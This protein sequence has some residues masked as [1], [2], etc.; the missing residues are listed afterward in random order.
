MNRKEYDHVVV[1]SGA[2]GATIAL[3]LAKK[4]KRILV[5]EQGKPEASIGTFN[6]CL[7]YF[8]L[9]K[10][11]RM[12]HYSEDGI[13][14]W[15]TLMAG[16]STIVSAA[17]GTPCLQ[18]ELSALGIDISKE[19]S[20]I[21]NELPITPYHL[22]RI[23]PGTRRIKESADALGYPMEQMPKFIDPRK[24]RRCGECTLGCKYNAKWTA[25][26][27]LEKSKDYSVEVRYGIKVIR[28][29]EKNGKAEALEILNGRGREKIAA[30]SVILAAGGI[31][32]PVILQNS[33][34]TGAG[35]NLF[36]DIFVN[37]YGTH[38]ELSQAREPQMT[39]VHHGS[40][41]EKGFILSPYI[42]H[43]LQLR[44]IELGL[45]GIKY[46]TN[47]LLGVMVKIRDDN[48]GKVSPSGKYSKQAT[49]ND[50]SKLKEGTDAASEILREAG[51]RRN[52]IMISK[53][54]GA[55]PGGT[56]A[57]GEVVNENLQTDIENFYV[58]DASVLPSAPGLPPIM[59]ILAL[60]K[61][62]AF[63]LN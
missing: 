39:L 36:L 37:V 44:V 24:C 6:N 34:I 7:R 46:N 52:S 62:L 54:Q 49:I 60:A 40:H 43:P 61:R 15:R 47:R 20:E 35:Q 13:I 58:C 25:L 14:L 51:V 48:S 30:N 9:K 63:S 42:N 1:G 18:E 50:R 55:H 8:D 4:G 10:Y 56:A 2:G 16:G 12:P 3:E 21:R 38:P 22:K 31:G 27:F 57:I 17:N 33:G 26:E 45:R 29:L 41:K 32:S 11:S 19:L 23:S 28:V 53:M 59:T 5:L